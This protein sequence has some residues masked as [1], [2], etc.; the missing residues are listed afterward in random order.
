MKAHGFYMS[1]INLGQFIKNV[2]DYSTGKMPAQ[3]PGKTANENFQRV[4][5]EAMKAVQQAAQNIADNMSRQ[6]DILNTQMMLKQLSS[7]EQSWLM[8]HMFDFPENLSQ[9]LEQIVTQG[10]TVT[11]KELA[12]LMTKELDLSKI[13]VL[14]QTNGKSALEKLSKMI[15][16]MNQSG[17]YNTQQLKEMSVLINACIPANDASQAQI[18]K[19]LMVVYLPWLPLNES[20]GFNFGSDSSEEGQKNAG[21]DMITIII[22]TKSYGIVKIL[23]YK[24]EQGFSMDVNCSESFPKE[25]FN[26]SVKLENALHLT[27][28]PSY[29]V[30]KDNEHNEENKEMKVEFSKSAKVSP[31]LLIII[32]SIIRI[33]TEI[34]NQGSLQEKRKENL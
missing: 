20:V 9:L 10:K 31:Q 23:L 1:E 22:T 33:I 6:Q 27:E 12:S 4:Q 28:N 29:T 24:E 3:Q 21:E 17:I 2:F 13:L 14:L 8:K 34:D 32:H 15:A 18:L 19:S 7:P 5:Q 16:T 25:R 26:E 30:R 11:S